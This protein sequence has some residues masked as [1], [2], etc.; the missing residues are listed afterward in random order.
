MFAL[1]GFACDPS[2]GGTSPTRD[3]SVGTTDGSVATCTDSDGDGISDADEGTGD[4]D[5]DG[6]PDYQ[7]DDSDGDDIPDEVERRVSPCLTPADS[8]D[9]GTPDF[10]D[11]E[12]DGNGIPDNE[13]WTTDTDGDGVPDF[14]DT[15]NDGD[16]I[17]D[18]T[19]IG[20]DP[21]APVDSD[22]D[23]LPDYLD[24]DSDDDTIGDLYEGTADTD[25][26]GIPD[27]FDLDSDADGISDA[28]EAGDDD[29]STPPVDTDDDGV[30]DYR[31]PD[32]DNDGIGDRDEV[33]AGTSPTN[34]DS[35]MDGASDLVEITAG[36]NPTDA[37]DN[38]RANGDFVF[39]MPYEEA[40]TP[41]RDTLDF[42]TNIRNADVYFLMD[43][44]GS[45]GSSI[46]ALRSAIASSLIPGI[47]A[48][49]PNTFVGLGEFRDYPTGTYG[50]AGDQPY[51]HFQDITDDVG[52]AT[53]ATA[54][55]TPSG[56]YDGPEAHGQAMYAVVTGDG[57]PYGGSSVGPRT[58]CPAG[59]FGWP[60]FRNNAVPIVVM[61]TDVTWHNGPGNANPYSA[62]S[63]EPE[64]AD[65]VAATMAR[66]VK[67]I[68][69][70]QG[71]GGMAHMQQFGRDVG[72]VDMAGEPFVQQ[73]SG[74]DAAL[75]A[76]VV[77]Q[78]RTLASQTP[79][80]ISTVFNDDAADAVDTAAAFLER[81]EANEAGDAAR[82]CAA[83]T[84]EDTNGDGFPDIFRDVL[85]GN[86]VCF[87]VVV[88][89]NVT[90]EPTEAPQL[91]RATV[92]VLGDGFTSLDERDVFFLVP[93]APVEIPLG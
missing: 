44:T 32:S 86:R 43:T 53:A 14:Q 76:A 55:Y 40:P 37:G 57:L 3:G 20:G 28:D 74:G 10:Q 49:I 58:D 38:P 70:G 67:F 7:D 19:E 30:A 48:E 85:P 17:D 39:L 56:G 61:I 18:V 83:R 52:A 69:I 90:V 66:N 75:T 72:S 78:V 59:T 6:T 46:N 91:F 65:V 88:K 23:G 60:C 47:R 25:M 63:G 13:E 34:A 93:P 64:Y 21:G 11:L 87:D 80:D 16:R 42:A 15:D 73:Y 33:A 81:L 62:I 89:T 35:D 36:T 84:G 79:L 22:G 9:D 5:G 51:G 41:P 71:A 26:D 68:G 92:E 77:D 54:R 82:G 2:D 29:L 24:P 50:Q 27:R 8:D 4:T 1:L 45:M 31:D 12:S